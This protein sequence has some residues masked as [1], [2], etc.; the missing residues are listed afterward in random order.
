MLLEILYIIAFLVVAFFVIRNLLRD[1]MTIGAEQRQPKRRRPQRRPPHPELIDKDG[2]VTDEPL[3]VI[4]STNLEE[5][6]NRLD[7]LFYESPD[8]KRD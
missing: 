1:V 3:L 7:E 2:N 6:R 5:A 8:E 4:R